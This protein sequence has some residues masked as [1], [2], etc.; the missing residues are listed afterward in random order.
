MK[1][2]NL[3]AEEI[4]IRVRQCDED[5]FSLLLY[6][7]SRIDMNILD[8]TVGE[9]KWQRRHYGVKDNMYCSVGIKCGEEWVWK[10]DCGVE[11]NTEKEKGEASDSFKRACVNWGIARELYTAPPMYIRGNIK[12]HSRSGKYIPTI[13][14]LYVSEIEISDNK[15]IEWLTIRDEKGIVIWSNKPKQIE[16]VPPIQQDTL[17]WEDKPQFSDQ[18][19]K[20]LTRAPINLDGLANVLNK[21]V[22]ELT[23]EDVIRALER[24]YA[25]KW[26]QYAND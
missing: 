15:I 23:D 16:K 4:E 25:D 9:N 22:A 2:R 19:E 1:F 21:G 6:I 11:S 7:D 26:K 18:I 8:E 13:R 3:R 12:K 20:A 17:P 5:G 24:K 14:G 10:D